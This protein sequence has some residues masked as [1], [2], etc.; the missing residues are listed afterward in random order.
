VSSANP[1]V[2]IGPYLVFVV[3]VL[4]VLLRVVRRTFANYRGT[5]FSLGRTVVFAA[6]YVILGIVFS[7][8][9]FFE[10]VPYLLVV[11]E[12]VLGAAAAVWSYRYSDKRVSFW[13]PAD[14]PLFF[15]GGVVIYLI[16]IVGLVT[17]LSIDL[18]FIGPAM[19]NFAS[20]LQLSGTALYGSMTTDLLLVFGVGL[21]IGRNV[22]VARRYRKIRRGEEVVPATAPPRAKS[23]LG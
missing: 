13:K 22:R 4:L 18:I 7:G 9:S 12:L 8:L 23:W 19:F 5:R 20:T 21:L 17:R 2:G 3:I 14:G 6:V 10:G 1:S 16:Y 11:P 15:R